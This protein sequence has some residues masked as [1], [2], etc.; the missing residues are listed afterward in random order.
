MAYG[1][2]II[3]KPDVIGVVLLLNKF[4][5]INHT[6][7]RTAAVTFSINAPAAPMATVRA[8]THG[9]YRNRTEPMMLFPSLQISIEV[10]FFSIGKRKFIQIFS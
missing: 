7:W 8:T 1:K 2:H 9:A 3:Y 6:L 4:H 5:F 10:N